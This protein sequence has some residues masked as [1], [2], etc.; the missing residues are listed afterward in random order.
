MT[1]VFQLTVQNNIRL[2]WGQS[3]RYIWPKCYT[4][5]HILK[6]V[7]AHKAFL[8]KFSKWTQQL[9]LIKALEMP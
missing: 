8:R 2:W 6:D 9:F 5:Q 3:G 4:K 7:M 1:Y